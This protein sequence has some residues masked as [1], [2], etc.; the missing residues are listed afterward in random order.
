MQRQE[1]K[2]FSRRPAP[3]IRRSKGPQGR[4][5]V[6]SARFPNRP[7]RR[8]QSDEERSGDP[9]NKSEGRGG[10]ERVGDA[11]H[12]GV[13]E[14]LVDPEDEQP[15]E[16][17]PEER[18]NGGEQGVLDQENRRDGLFGY[19]QRAQH[20]DLPGLLL[21][22]GEAA[23]AHEEAGDRQEGES[24]RQKDVEEDA[25]H[26][27]LDLV[28]GAGEL[29]ARA[30][31]P[32]G[33][34]MGERGRGLGVGLEAIGAFHQRSLDLQEE[35]RRD[36]H[37]RSGALVD[38]RDADLR[39]EREEVR[40]ALVDHPVRR[41]VE[42]LVGILLSH[43]AGGGFA[44]PEEVGEGEVRA[45]GD[46]E[47]CWGR[48]D[49][50]GLPR[51]GG[52]GGHGVEIGLRRPPREGEVPAMERIGYGGGDDRLQRLLR[53]EGEGVAG[54]K[55]VPLL[56]LVGLVGEMAGEVAGLVAEIEALRPQ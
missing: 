3:R 4:G 30:E 32:G 52:V 53:D 16:K 45:D 1:Q 13:H 10:E 47:A 54:L 48:P 25:V 2:L 12:P 37:L 42:I 5:D 23:E 26:R 31:G 41:G 19:A 15:P 21:D 49:A 22:V 6:N 29:Q 38:A 55:K 51:V 24:D 35:S 39:R 43:E 18:R 20:G 17:E 9:E 33:E 56:V 40:I 36:E 14:G 27:R 46:A 8:R 28:D 11:E 50:Q 34:A 44:R 7:D